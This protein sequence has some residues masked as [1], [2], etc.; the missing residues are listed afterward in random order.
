M[1]RILG[2]DY[3][4]KRIGLALSDPT[5]LI[6]SP[7]DTLHFST[8]AQLIDRIKEI[9]ASQE[10][11]VVVVGMPY[12]MK[13]GESNQTESVRKFVSA[14]EAAGIPAKE[15]DERLSSVSAKRALVEQNKKT[16]KDKGLV[17]QTAAAIMLQQYLDRK[18]RG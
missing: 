11:E 14:L 1:G 2:I 17:D 16:G 3:G 4:S 15:E 10:V 12:R 13:G 6:A 7:F 18:R 5:H 9:I 8:E